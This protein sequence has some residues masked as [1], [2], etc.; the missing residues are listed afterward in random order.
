MA[1]LDC[2]RPTFW[3][4][5]FSTGITTIN[6]RMVHETTYC[7]AVLSP[8]DGPM[9]CRASSATA[10]AP[11]L[12]NKPT[13]QEERTNVTLKDKEAI[14]GDTV[15]NS[16]STSLSPFVSTQLKWHQLQQIHLLSHTVSC[17][18][19]CFLCHQDSSTVLAQF[20]VPSAIRTLQPITQ[21]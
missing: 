19:G 9:D 18:M 17:S 20:L 21:K 14:Q 15:K 16:E 7:K 13:T 3:Y 12:A 8:W 6:D 4:G 10:P 1:K 11:T 2:T 5:L